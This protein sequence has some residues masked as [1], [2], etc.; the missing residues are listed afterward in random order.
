MK[1]E[2]RN[3]STGNIIS[4]IEKTPIDFTIKGKKK[5][6]YRKNDTS[7]LSPFQVWQNEKHYNLFKEDEFLYKN[8]K[9][10]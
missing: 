8:Y 9:V 6:K 3:N 10:K 5:F 7:S 2:R 4:L 1:P